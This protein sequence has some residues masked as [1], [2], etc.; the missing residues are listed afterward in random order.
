M[1][2]KPGDQHS[3]LKLLFPSEPPPQLFDFPG[4][5]RI[6]AQ[7]WNLVALVCREH[8]L[9]WYSKL[10]RDKS[11]FQEVVRIVKH[12][13][14]QIGNHV[15]ELDLPALLLSDIPDLLEKH[16]RDHQTAQKRANT[17]A[18]GNL[19]LPQLYYSLHPHIA[20]R[21][22]S[23]H[24]VD[25]KLPFIA[26]PYMIAVVEGILK[27][28][29]PPEDFAAES[30]RTVVREVLIYVVF[31]NLFTKLAQPWFIH[32]VIT[33]VLSTDPDHVSVPISLPSPPPSLL[34]RASQTFTRALSLLSSF[35]P[36]T[37]SANGPDLCLSG[38]NL[39]AT[40]FRAEER[41]LLQ[42]T[43]WWAEISSNLLNGALN[44]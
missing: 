23:I 39:S 28:V 40:V 13:V 12:V 37:P 25:P 14:E 6:N 38:I 43:F 21:P 33:K 36:F 11:F 24:P 27:V 1:S 9:S 22:P 17:P 35:S 7:I 20:L 34:T 41:P 31:G 16:Y 2:S 18:G 5:Q 15:K 42:Q 4:S 19:P 3:A 8:V 10:T 44:K 26:S 32:T 29:L 30:E